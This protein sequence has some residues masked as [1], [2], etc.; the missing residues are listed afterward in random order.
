MA[1]QQ[2]SEYL[3]RQM[4]PYLKAFGSKRPQMALAYLGKESQNEMNNLLIQVVTALPKPHSKNKPVMEQKS[5]A[6][7]AITTETLKME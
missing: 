4:I 2:V 1:I 7:A 3:E 6:T 5:G